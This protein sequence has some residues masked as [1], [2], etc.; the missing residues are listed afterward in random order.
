MKICKPIAANKK[1][2][3][4][5]ILV[6]WTA[7]VGRIRLE[8]LTSTKEIRT[9]TL[10]ATIMNQ[11]DRVSVNTIMVKSIIAHSTRVTIA[12]HG[13]LAHGLM[14]MDIPHEK[15]ETH[16]SLSMRTKKV[17]GPGLKIKEKPLG[18]SMRATIR[19]TSGKVA[20]HQTHKGI[21]MK[22]KGHLNLT[23][24]V[25]NVSCTGVANAASV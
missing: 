24:I 8:M 6:I 2:R 5:G 9:R 7:A 20:C 18:L 15:V 17:I 23:A 3:A 10:F 13:F 16:S 21:V 4:S 14:G 25:L 1:G 22:V 12:N 19:P 11:V